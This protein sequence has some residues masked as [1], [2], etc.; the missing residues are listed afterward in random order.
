MSVP[1]KRKA[2]DNNILLR[3]LLNNNSAI[4]FIPNN[5]NSI[6]M[7]KGYKSLK[8]IE[9]TSKFMSNNNIPTPTKAVAV[10]NFE[11]END[12]LIF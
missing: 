2:S 8:D 12:C 3:R 1:I 9:I 10:K 6:G 4:H 11:K 7:M 5:I